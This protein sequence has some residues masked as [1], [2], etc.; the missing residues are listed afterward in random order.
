VSEG[1]LLALL[2][3][4]ATVCAAG[5]RWIVGRVTEHE[6]RLRRLEVGGHQEVNA[7][8]LKLTEFF[9]AIRESLARIES[10]LG[11][12]EN[13]RNEERNQR[14]GRGGQGS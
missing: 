6:D 3:A 7:I 8:E 2:G 11:H 1:I 9:G 14:Y 5:F 13:S 10:R 4:L 12:L